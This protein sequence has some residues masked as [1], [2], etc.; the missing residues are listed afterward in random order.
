MSSF[1][2]REGHGVVALMRYRDKAMGCAHR[3]HSLEG[4]SGKR[5]YGCAGSIGKDFNLPPPDPLAPAGAQGLENGFLGGETAGHSFMRGGLASAIRGFRLRKNR[6][7]VFRR[8]FFY[9]FHVEYV[10]ADAFYHIISRINGRREG[11][12]L[13]DYF[14]LT[15][16]T[17]MAILLHA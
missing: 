11:P 5:G 14:T 12:R 2:D 17:R 7:L 4:L 13:A 9:P 1:E 3:K 8:Q 6:R 10:G 15:R 16:R